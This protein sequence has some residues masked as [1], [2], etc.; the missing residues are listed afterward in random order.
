MNEDNLMNSVQLERSMESYAIDIDSLIEAVGLTTF[1]NHLVQSR[2]LLSKVF[3]FI[4]AHYQD[5][6]S[7]QDVAKAVG[8]SPAYLTDLVRKE[9]GK[10]VLGWIIERRM[11]KARRLLFETDQT[12]EKIAE[13]IGY[14]D[15]GYF[16]R[17][18]LRLH[19]TSPQVWR[20]IQR[21]SSIPFLHIDPQKMRTSKLMKQKSSPPSAVEAQRLQACVQEIATILYNNGEQ[22]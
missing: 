1:Q 13:A 16:S 10:T 4:E 11:I 5:S 12:V 8:R 19:G 2:P 7:L 20:K 21:S 15:R 22:T 9:T 17:Q 18:F 3:D 14:F 6:I